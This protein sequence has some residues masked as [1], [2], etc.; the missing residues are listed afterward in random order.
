M[1]DDEL[2]QYLRVIDERTVEMMKDYSNRTEAFT[3]F[4]IE[5]IQSYINLGEYSIV[6]GEHCNRLGNCM[7]ALDAYAF[8]ENGE[9]LS[10]FYTIYNESTDGS[11]ASITN[12]EFQTALNKMQGFY[13]LVASGAYKDFDKTD[14]TLNPAIEIYERLHDVVAV[15]LYVLS[16]CIVKGEGIKNNRISGKNV[17]WEIWDIRKLYANLNG[18]K[19][20]VE[21]DIDFKNDENFQAYKIPY[22]EMESKDF[23]Y[24]CMLMMIPA[25]MLY[26]LY[27]K[28]NTNLLLNNVRFFLGFKGS[29]KNNSNIGI[30]ETLKGGESEMFLAYNNGITALAADVETENSSGK[31]SIDDQDKNGMISTGFVTKISDFRIVNGG[32]TTASI[33]F[34]KRNHRDINLSKVYVQMKL[35][36]LKDNIDS[37]AGNITRYSNSQNKIKYADFSVSNEF[38]TTME[39]LSRTTIIPNRRNDSIFWYYE[40]IRGQYDQ[41]K[42]RN[43]TKESNAIFNMEF[44]KEKKFKKE[45]LAKV[46]K[47]WKHEPFDAVK[48]EATNYD[49]YISKMVKENFV[50]DETY[51]KES[52][53]LL[54][55]YRFLLSRPQC[56]AYGNRKATIVCYTLALL[57]HYSFGRFDLI[58]NIWETQ[59]VPAELKNFLNHLSNQVDEAL[60]VLAEQSTVLSYGKR[61]T[62]YQE[63]IDYGL[64]VSSGNLKQ[65]WAEK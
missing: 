59:E 31:T 62:T 6:H 34:A 57:N 49:M 64:K 29:K 61:K 9:V 23:D 27:E 5:E 63:L 36:I 53:S 4:V 51:F 45:E 28:H 50:P 41:D 18:I 16:N 54:I 38:N 33:F 46:W 15:K 10:L 52:I 25:K 7:G 65:F 21:I 40:R 11:I 32:Q 8:S 56:K 14:T 60:T 44:P 26:K 2:K 17:D 12:T 43:K 3:A 37:T 35:V 39:R 42:A 58:K 24:K 55:I 20:H 1:Q 13:K 19:D 47:S 48:G 30:Q 22:I